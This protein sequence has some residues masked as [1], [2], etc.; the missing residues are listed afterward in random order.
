MRF[1]KLS[2]DGVRLGLRWVVDIGD[3]RVRAARA[4]AFV[5]AFYGPAA[6]R[7]CSTVIAVCRQQ[8][9]SPRTF[10]HYLA[11]LDACGL[12]WADAEV[13]GGCDAKGRA[14]F[15]ASD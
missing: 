3:H 8:G 5:Y 15:A 1:R 6:F 7:D 2:E 13:G 10:R 14:G 11:E 12:R 9:I 4:S